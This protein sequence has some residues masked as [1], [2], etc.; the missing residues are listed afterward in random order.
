MI[1][2]IAAEHNLR[3]ELQTNMTRVEIEEEFF[4]SG[5]G[6]WIMITSK[7]DRGQEVVG[8]IL[9]S[10]VLAFTIIPEQQVEAPSG[11]KLSH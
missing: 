8:R 2:A 9:R 11:I 7:D 10:C 4:G 1:V 3:M 6:P 5:R